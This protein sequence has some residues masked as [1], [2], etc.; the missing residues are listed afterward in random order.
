M[1]ILDTNVV[2]EVMRSAPSPA[3]MAWMDA[4]PA[5]TMYLT[6]VTVA[7]LG[8]GMAL[9]PK[10]RRKALLEEISRG[11]L[12]LFEG[13]VLSFDVAAASEYGQRAAWAQS[14]G[15]CLP[16][17]DGYI[18]AIAAAR[19]YGVATRDT[20]PFEAAGLQVFNPWQASN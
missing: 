5:E 10:G 7:E 20:A 17:A 8:F 6:T 1:I 19:G 16:V 15:R 4:Q 2:S 18:A 9:L 12:E 11:L 13:R 3:V 14:A